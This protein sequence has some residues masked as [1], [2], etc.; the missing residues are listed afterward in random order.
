[1]GKKLKPLKPTVTQIKRV[2][3]ELVGDGFFIYH[4]GKKK[5]PNIDGGVAW[6]DTE[7]IQVVEFR[8][9]QETGVLCDRRGNPLRYYVDGAEMTV[10]PSVELE[11]LRRA[12][13]NAV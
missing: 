4:M 8:V 13:D 1:V 11:T 12:A 2:A 5:E 6:S 10:I 7:Y 3:R 9:N